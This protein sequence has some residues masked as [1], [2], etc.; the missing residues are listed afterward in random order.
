[1]SS[2]N[3][4]VP[5]FSGGRKVFDYQQSPLEQSITVSL[6][7]NLGSI[8]RPARLVP[9]KYNYLSRTADPVYTNGNTVVSEFT[10]YNL[11]DKHIFTS[12]HRVLIDAYNTRYPELADPIFSQPDPED[13]MDS[14][15]KIGK[16]L[17]AEDKILETIKS[18]IVERYGNLAVA[19]VLTDPTV[20]FPDLLLG[21]PLEIFM[22]GI[23]KG[24]ERVKRSGLNIKGKFRGKFVDILGVLR[25]E[26][27][28][29]GYERLANP[30]QKLEI[31]YPKRYNQLNK[32]YIKAF[33][34]EMLS[35]LEERNIS[36]DYD[37]YCPHPIEPAYNLD[38][39]LTYRRHVD[40]VRQLA[41][42]I[43]ALAEEV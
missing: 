43:K 28:F 29:K 1:M 8:L 38:M 36:S 35:D 24:E 41:T 30:T 7:E 16:E 26:P 15:D 14:W 11:L 5:L 27:F 9:G 34:P 4:V 18:G 33:S 42:M 20:F 21:A 37:S 3:K 40:S 13:Y 25:S 19:K 2:E 32:A 22:F 17:A 31:T 39:F 6:Q 10:R 12:Y 23:I